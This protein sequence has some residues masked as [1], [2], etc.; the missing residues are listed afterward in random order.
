MLRKLILFFIFVISFALQSTVFQYISI[1]GIKPNLMLILIIS[2]S[3]LKDKKVGGYV[4]LSAG[5][6]QDILFGNVIGINGLIY[7][8]IG[9]TVGLFNGSM[10]KGNPLV[11]FL[12]TFI[13]TI[14]SN[15]MYFI[16]YY[17]S[18]ADI[19]FVRMLTN[20]ALIEAIYNSILSVFIFILIRRL[21][22]APKLSFVKRRR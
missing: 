19:T 9:Y 4:G 22:T 7:F 3:L 18:S 11:P 10:F 1:M 16:F 5:L 17:F 21:Y 15:I 8:L 14:F 13:S 20:I 2:I 6:L 12:V